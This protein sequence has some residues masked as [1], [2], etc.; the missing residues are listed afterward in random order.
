VVRAPA[1]ADAAFRDTLGALRRE[2]D[3]LDEDIVQ[4]LA[5]RMKIAERI[6]RYKRENNVTILQVNR[7]EEIVRT[8][9][10]IGRAMGLDD[11]FLRDLL[12]LIHHESIQV[13]TRVM[14]DGADRV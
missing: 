10:A 14:N 13:Q 4:K 1:T 5:A 12:R 8:R 9:G 3:Q 2:I 11:G 7:W 6:G